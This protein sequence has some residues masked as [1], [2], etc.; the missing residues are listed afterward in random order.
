MVRSAFP[1]ASSRLA[2]DTYILSG[3]VIALCLLQS[4]K[5]GAS[6]GSASA[7]TGTE[8]QGISWSSSQR[9]QVAL[10]F[11]ANGE[12]LEAPNSRADAHDTESFRNP[13]YYSGFCR[14]DDEAPSAGTWSG[15][16]M[17]C[18]SLQ[19]ENVGG[20]LFVAIADAS[21]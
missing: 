4:H 18:N 12:E 15:V 3:R 2:Q 1:P 7:R 16:S 20:S 6:L 21:D 17:V 5:S 11:A 9:D 19:Q 13:Y 14:R 8:T 10:G